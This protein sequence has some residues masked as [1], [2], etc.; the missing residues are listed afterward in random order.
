MTWIVI[1]GA[2]PGARLGRVQVTTK[3]ASPQLQPVPDALVKQ[4]EAYW[5]RTMPY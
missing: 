4:I 3:A 5:A 1:V 2:A